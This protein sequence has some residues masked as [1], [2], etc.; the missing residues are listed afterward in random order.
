[1]LLRVLLLDSSKEGMYTIFIQMLV[2]SKLGLGEG[3]KKT[4]TNKQTQNGQALQITQNNL[5]QML[6]SC[7]VHTYY[8]DYVRVQ[9]TQHKMNDMYE[10]RKRERET[11]GMH[12]RG[13]TT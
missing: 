5:L 6:V 9:H 8:R 13:E 10:S 2:L 4:K 12:G 7:N 1:M 11:D 3:L